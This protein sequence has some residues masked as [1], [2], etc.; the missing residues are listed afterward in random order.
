M[1]NVWWLRQ[2]PFHRPFRLARM[3]E[4]SGL[5]LERFITVRI[6]SFTLASCGGGSP[7]GPAQ[8]Q[9]QLSPPAPTLAVG[10]Y[11][12]ITAQTTPPFQSTMAR[13]IGAF[14]G[15]TITFARSL[16]PR[17]FPTWRVARTV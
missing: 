1:R 16:F 9:I 4:S 13:W 7:A 3:G 15:R 8:L 5:Y 12:Q 17:A 10:T 14:K 11:V 2:L 6:L